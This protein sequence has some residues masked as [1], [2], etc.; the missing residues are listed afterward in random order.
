[1]ASNGKNNVSV[2]RWMWIMFV[3]AIPCVGF[4]MMFVWAFTGKNETR[5]NYFKALIGWFVVYLVIA[6]GLAATGITAVIQKRFDEGIK[7]YAAEQAKAKEKSAP[8]PHQKA[9]DS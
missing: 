6:A 3:L 7:A 2:L 5:R 1:M 4:V 8:K 9:P